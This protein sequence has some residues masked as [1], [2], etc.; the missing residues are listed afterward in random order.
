MKLIRS[1]PDPAL[2]R[3]DDRLYHELFVYPTIGRPLFPMRRHQDNAGGEGVPQ[4]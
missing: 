2:K 1:G 3:H 4:K